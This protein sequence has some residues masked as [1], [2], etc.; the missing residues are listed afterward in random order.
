[1]SEDIAATM[2]YNALSPPAL[3]NG[4]VFTDDRGVG[5]ST[6]MKAMGDESTGMLSKD[7]FVKYSWR[8]LRFIVPLVLVCVATWQMLMGMV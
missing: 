3:V 7:E 4:L 8:W 2:L 6:L 1:M 5:I